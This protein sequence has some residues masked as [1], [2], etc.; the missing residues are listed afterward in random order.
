NDNGMN[1]FLE[2]CN[3]GKYELMKKLVIDFQ[4]NLGS[5]NP[6]TK[7]CGLHYAAIYNNANIIQ[8]ILQNNSSLKN[9]Q[10]YQLCTPLF[11]AALNNSEKC[12]EVLLNF[13]ANIHLKNI[14]NFTPF[15][16]TTSKCIKQMFLSKY[17]LI[18]N[19]FYS[20][21]QFENSNFLV[22]NSRKD[23]ISNLLQKVK[24]CQNQQKE[25]RFEENNQKKINY[26]K[27]YILKLIE[28][29]Q[30]QLIK[31][32]T[33]TQEYIEQLKIQNDN[34]KINQIK[35]EQKAEL[36]LKKKISLEDFIFYRSI[37]EGAFGEVFLVT[38][39]EGVLYQNQESQ[40]LKND[41]LYALK[42]LKKE[43]LKKTKMDKYIQAEKQIMQSFNHPFIAKLNLSFQNDTHLFIL[44]DF[45]QGG[46]L[47]RILAEN[48]KIEEKYIKIW[49]SQ[50]VLALEEL[51]NKDII[52]RDLKPENLVLDQDGNLQLIDFGLCKKGANNLTGSFCGTPIYLPPE[53]VD[54]TGH[55]KM[56][57]WYSLGVIIYEMLIGRPPYFSTDYDKLYNEIKTAPLRLPKSLPQ[58]S[59]DILI[60]L[61][62]KN[63]NKRLGYKNDAQEVKQ[64]HWFKDI[65]WQL[66]LE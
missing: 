60:G 3:S 53:V 20:R 39:K 6:Q 5:I 36:K 30:N 32:E 58:E 33:V 56:V 54:K 43:M 19:D 55:N 12:V 13:D 29:T 46:D 66:V 51:H 24:I 21:S 64:H 45:F 9:F 40:I 7:R 31:Q 14:Q 44:M 62:K 57:D 27:K 1:A 2:C 26:Q 34:N 52:Y 10:D 37:G 25:K 11:L 16:V 47:G 28:K 61:L 49:A 65:D 59:K 15:E 38:F 23:R 63:Y 42:V 48:I 50:V 22:Q 18:N 4:S 8:F 35:P 41:K 17:T